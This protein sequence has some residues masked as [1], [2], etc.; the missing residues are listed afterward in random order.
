MQDNRPCH[1]RQHSPA[2]RVG[3][4]HRRTSTAA[5]GEET[6]VEATELDAF[7][8]DVRLRA[9][10]TLAPLKVSSI[11]LSRSSSQPLR[12]KSTIH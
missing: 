9:I 5:A 4:R 2:R 11:V 3:R 7:N 8:N 12:G 1:R 6:T 10:R